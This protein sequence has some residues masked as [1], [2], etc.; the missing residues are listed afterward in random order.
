MDNKRN[1]R[2]NS[3]E[4]IS[5]RDHIKTLFSTYLVSLEIFQQENY[6]AKE[7][8]SLHNHYSQ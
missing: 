2:S 3:K 4:K 8:T 5:H 7:K 6:F 1:L